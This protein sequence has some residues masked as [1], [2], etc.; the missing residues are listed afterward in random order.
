[1]IGEGVFQEPEP[2]RITSL[3][4]AE[5]FATY[6][7][8]YGTSIISGYDVSGHIRNTYKYSRVHCEDDRV[9]GKLLNAYIDLELTYLFM[10][11]DVTL[12]GG[13]HNQLHSRGMIASGAVLEDFELFSGK[14]DILYVL[15]ALSFRTRA[16][17]DKFMG[18]L[19]LLYEYQK[20]EKFIREKSRKAYFV[21]NAQNWPEISLHFRKC[22]TNVIRTW[23]V[24]SGQRDVVKK[25][26]N[27][28]LIIPFPDPFLK[29]MRDVIGMVD[30]IRTPEAH[31]SGFLR[32]W[33]LA[34]FP[35]D[36]SRDF[37]LVNYCNVASEFMNAL[38]ATIGEYSAQNS[39]AC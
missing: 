29:I 37:A 2:F 6:L 3:Q 25:I 21:K 17:W 12:A 16:F 1:M 27:L 15:S 14:A 19:F 9:N 10:M 36:K 39:S 31:G 24:H 30:N 4:D 7:S 18:I 20:Y 38:R 32:K 33:T 13:I 26:D 8:R 34:N 22:L 35:V 11:K 28:N 23:L 5:D